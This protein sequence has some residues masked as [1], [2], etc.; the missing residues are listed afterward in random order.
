[1]ASTIGCSSRS[2]SRTEASVEYPVLV[3][4]DG[5]SASFS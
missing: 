2:D 3:R 5:L 4:F 1:M